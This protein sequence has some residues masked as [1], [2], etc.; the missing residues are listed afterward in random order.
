M[1]DICPRRCAPLEGQ[2]GFCG[3][4]GNRNGKII[5]IN[6][7]K[8][9]ALALDPIE[10]KPLAR[11]YPGSFIL[12]AG[13][14][15]CNLN[16]PFC[17]NSE[18]ARAKENSILW[19]EVSP[20]RLVRA[21]Q[22]AEGNIGIALT[23]N[24]PLVGYEYAMDVFLLAKEKGLKTV[25]VTNGYAEE[26]PFS[27]LLSRTDA[28]NIDLKGFT[29]DFYRMLGGELSVVKRNIVLAAKKCHV[30]LTTLIIPG[31]NDSV[32]EMERE[33][34]WIARINPEIPLHISRFF[35]RYQ[36]MDKPATGEGTIHRL[37]DTARNYLRY[38]Y[39]G[40]L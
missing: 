36:M 19:Q 13:S 18:I 15:G 16:C 37:A 2:N 31:E 9:T 21:A 3:A 22:E 23:Y 30:E 35:P 33:A 32:E 7:G 17:Q 20:E 12:S 6:Y 39:R 34:A 40:N 8:I 38:V 27:K 4:R 25:L 24:E 5:D 11:F 14:F 1:C 10:K 29:R 26:A 28:L